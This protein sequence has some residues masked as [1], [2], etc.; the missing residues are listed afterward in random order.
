MKRF[1]ALLLTAVFLLSLLGGCASPGAP[2]PTED[3]VAFTDSLGRTVQL[4]RE[5][6]RVAPSG[7]VAS[8][9]LATIAPEYMVCI[10]ASPSSAQYPYLPENLIKLPTTGQM[11]GSKSTLNLETLL[12][13]EPQ[14]VIDLGD[15]KENMAA[16]LDALQRQIGVPVIFIEA[17]VVHM[18]E[19]YRTLGSILS[20]KAERGDAL[21]DFAAQTVALAEEN[22][23]KITD[24]ERVRVMYTSGTSGLDTNAAG[25]IQAQ[26]LALVGAENAIVVPEE[27][28]S[29]RGGGNTVNLEQLYSFDPDV[30]L[31]SAGSIY[32]GA[33]DDAAWRGLSAIRGGKYYEIPGLPYNWLSNPP[34]INMLLGV[35]WLGD[36]L[37][38]QYYDYDMTDKAQEI[39]ALL[40]GYE[41]SDEEAASM[42]A[43]SSRKDAA[44]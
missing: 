5:L 12:S 18:E 17:D 15:R 25:S 30:I 10:S 34:S 43:N 41:L 8:M 6:T 38:P 28:V 42:L 4:P 2:E 19:M 20:G 35:W 26:V 39:F 11:Y 14:V 9:I 21:A 16:D 24:A 23:A 36:L 44:A 40:W 31:F 1:L 27:E 13:C 37:Y 3:T 33:A 22:R 7:A 32:A 29:N